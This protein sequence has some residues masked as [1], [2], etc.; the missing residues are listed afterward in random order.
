MDLIIVN[1]LPG[2]GKTSIAKEISLK[3]K[4]PLIMKD[5]IKEFLFD[6]L[7][8]G[9]REWSTATG[10]LSYKYLY[11]LTDFMLSR[12]QSIIIENAFE[13]QFSKPTLEEIIRKYDVDK[14]FEI[15]CC[16]DKETRRKRYKERNESG[17]RHKGHVDHLNYLSDSDPEPIEKYGPLDIGHLIRIDTTNF[18]IVNIDKI[19]K[20]MSL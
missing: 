17:S 5:G 9:D 19:I 4:L 13:R 16:S 15:Y 11:D 1:G 10:K 12:G 20:E 3:L 7:G 18:S 14:I 2:T 8:V 6:T